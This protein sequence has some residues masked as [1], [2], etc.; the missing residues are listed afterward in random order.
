MYSSTSTGSEVKSPRDPYRKMQSPHK[1]TVPQAARCNRPM[2]LPVPHTAHVL[3]YT[4]LYTSGGIQESILVTKMS[5][6]T[7]ARVGE[8]GVPGKCTYVV[9]VRYDME[10]VQLLKCSKM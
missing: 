1:T 2:K 4:L 3:Q 10:F 8:Y 7:W 9:Q 6:S 5:K